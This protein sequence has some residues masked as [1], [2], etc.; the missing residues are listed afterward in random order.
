VQER[1][2][3]RKETHKEHGSTWWC[4]RETHSGKRNKKKTDTRS[5]ETHKHTH[6]TGGKENTTGKRGKMRNKGKRC[7]KKADRNER[8]KE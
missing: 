2:T 8:E 7:T 3:H 1:D 6:N 4:V 5:E